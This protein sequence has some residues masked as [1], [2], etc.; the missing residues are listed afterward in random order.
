MY[1]DYQ[2]RILRIL[3]DKKRITLDN[4]LAGLFI[5]YTESKKDLEFHINEVQTQTKMK[6]IMPKPC[7]IQDDKIDEIEGQIQDFQN[8]DIKSKSE[9]EPY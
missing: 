9:E 8:K 3:D 5:D 1:S 2:I 7:E 6:D 4:Q